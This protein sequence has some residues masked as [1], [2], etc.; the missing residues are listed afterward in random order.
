MA[1]DA[2]DERRRVLGLG[3]WLS[4]PKIRIFQGLEGT[5]KVFASGAGDVDGANAVTRF[6]D[7]TSS[8]LSEKVVL[9]TDTKSAQHQEQAT[10]VSPPSP[11]TTAPGAV[12]PSSRSPETSGPVPLHLLS[13][14]QRLAA[15]QDCV[16]RTKRI[17][18]SSR[19]IDMVKRELLDLEYFLHTRGHVEL[20]ERLSAYTKSCEAALRE[21][22]FGSGGENA[23]VGVRNR[24]V[25]GGTGKTAG[26]DKANGAS[27]QR[28]T[29]LDGADS[30]AAPTIAGGLW[31][32][33]TGIVSYV[34]WGDDSILQE[35]AGTAPKPAVEL[36]AEH[37]DL[38]ER[39]WRA[40]FGEFQKSEYTVQQISETAVATKNF[41]LELGIL[42]VQ[43]FWMLVIP[44]LLM[45]D[46]LREAESGGGG[47]RAAGTTNST[48]P[49]TPSIT[50]SMASAISAA[51]FF[52]GY[53]VLPY[54]LK[55]MLLGGGA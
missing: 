41:T 29:F 38:L 9:V 42:T 49:E 4:A 1:A 11:D 26:K 5:S 14:H 51:F 16:L 2:A 15:L 20:P 43:G 32:S 46:S 48:S 7:A 55:D 21:K 13:A 33:V 50:V 25:Y 23:D 22:Q 8:G 52:S 18:D 54:L 45:W 36:L 3:A 40:A 19:P 27:G 10:T 47:R 6:L 44:G 37:L 28:R 35:S 31:T 24:I 30:P 34:V 12:V 17:Q 53:Y 39:N